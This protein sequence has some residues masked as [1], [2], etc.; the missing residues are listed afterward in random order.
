MPPLF[1]IS[2]ALTCL[3]L[4]WL[5]QKRQ[6]VLF[7]HLLK[8]LSSTLTTALADP[9]QCWKLGKWSHFLHTFLSCQATPWALPPRDSLL[10][11]ALSH[12]CKVGPVPSPLV[13][14]EGHLPPAALAPT[15]GSP[16]RSGSPMRQPSPPP[17][18]SGRAPSQRSASPSWHHQQRE[19]CPPLLALLHFLCGK[20]R[21]GKNKT[22]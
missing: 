21:T 4:K 12:P 6:M 17:E 2:P 5:S 7:V 3:L 18:P 20:V 14:G 1:L 22:R 11:V 8:H 19:V 16:G 9:S 10:Q 15:R 13:C